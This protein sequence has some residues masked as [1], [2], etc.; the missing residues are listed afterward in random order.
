MHFSGLHFLYVSI[1]MIFLSKHAVERNLVR[2]SYEENVCKFT[3]KSMQS[4]KRTCVFRNAQTD[5]QLTNGVNN[6][7]SLALCAP[8]S[9]KSATLSTLRN[10]LFVK[11]F[12]A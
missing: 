1:S 6:N 8:L 9:Y 3:S 5:E 4:C 7:S 12:I 10:T 11:N 2:G